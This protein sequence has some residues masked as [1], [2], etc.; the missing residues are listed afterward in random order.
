VAPELDYVEHVETC[1]GAESRCPVW[2][3]VNIN[4]P[5]R[6][7][8]ISFRS[9]PPTAV[10]PDEKTPSIGWATCGGRSPGLRV[11]A[12]ARL[13]GFPVAI[14]N[15]Y[16]PPTVAGAATVLNGYVFSPCSLFSF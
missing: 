1:A 15:A 5:I 9:S 10:R 7:D 12:G 11:D 6:S 8:T 3:M 14:V 2:I 4:K 16:Y 13:P